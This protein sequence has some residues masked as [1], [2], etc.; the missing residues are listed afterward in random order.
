MEISCLLCTSRPDS[1]RWP[2]FLCSFSSSTGP[3]A[4][5]STSSEACLFFSLSPQMGQRSIPSL[6]TPVWKKR[7][8]LVSTP[9]HP[10]PPRRVIRRCASPTKQLSLVFCSRRCAAPP[11]RR[12]SFFFPKDISTRFS[13]S[14]K[15][16]SDRRTLPRPDQNVRKPDKGAHP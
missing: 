16:R 7:P 8:L 13:L 15:L 14:Q 3:Y 5:S 4:V 1:L 6:T 9:S 12:N 10:P 11:L 2:L